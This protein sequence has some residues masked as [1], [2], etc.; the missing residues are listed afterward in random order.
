MTSCI[1]FL[2]EALFSNESAG[3][4]S[5]YDFETGQIPPEAFLA[6]LAPVKEFACNLSY[7]QNFHEIQGQW[8]AVSVKW[9]S[10]FVVVYKGGTAHA[11]IHDFLVLDENTYTSRG[12]SKDGKDV[13]EIGHKN[14][15]Q[16]YLNFDVPGMVL[17]YFW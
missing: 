12:T 3:I 6:S 7:S 8:A 10:D 11:N 1:Q 17:L 9:L 14:L 5:S 2:V 16:F 13:L 4:N 15:P